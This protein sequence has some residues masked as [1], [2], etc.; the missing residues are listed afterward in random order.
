MS[1]P[2]C[3]F[4]DVLGGLGPQMPQEGPKD[5][6]RHTPRPKSYPKRY[7][8]GCQTRDFFDV[9]LAIAR[10]RGGKPTVVP[11]LLLRARRRAPE[12]SVLDFFFVF[13]KPWK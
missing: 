5:P 4:L 11:P 1:P 10:T 6:P 7:L 8:T 13:L 12:S 2:K 3:G 9:F